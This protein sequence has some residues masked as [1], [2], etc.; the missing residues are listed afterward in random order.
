MFK[1]M[2]LPWITVEG[3]A[4]SSIGWFDV[5]FKL[6]YEMLVNGLQHHDLDA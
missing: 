5:S 1:S 3:D 4:A 2:A 6:A